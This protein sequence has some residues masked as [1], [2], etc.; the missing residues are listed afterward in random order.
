MIRKT[1]NRLPVLSAGTAIFITFSLFMTLCPDLLT[2]RMPIS[3]KHK[4]KKHVKSE[5]RKH[6]KPN[7]HHHESH[8][9]HKHH[10]AIFSGATSNIEQKHTN[11]TLGAEYEYRLPVWQNRI[12]VGAVAERV[13]ADH[14]ET[15]LAG[16]ALLHAGKGL[17]FLLASGVVVAEEHHAE[18][19]SLH[20]DAEGG[21]GEEPA[22][23]ETGTAKEFLLRAGLAKAF[24]AGRF[25]ITPALNFDL[26][27]GNLAVVYGLCFGRGF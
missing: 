12:G 23:G 14:A 7:Q 4:D 16:A 5:K 17:K 13:F 26:I 1:H 20:A 24:H 6:P 2:A 18:T 27:N 22:S 15:V 10:F 8:V 9:V 21:H 19:V 25:S 11:F 3:E